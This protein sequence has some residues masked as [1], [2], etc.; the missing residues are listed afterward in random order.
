MA[1]RRLLH[2]RDEEVDLTLRIAH[3]G[4]AGVC[5][6]HDAVLAYVALVERQSADLALVQALHQL[7]AGQHVVRM[8]PAV[9]VLPAHLVFTVTEHL[10]QRAVDD[11]QASVRRRQVDTDR[12]VLEQGAE[13]QLAGAQSLFG[14][15]AVG[16]VTRHHH[17][18][19][20]RQAE[21]EVLHPQQ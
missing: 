21:H 17:Q 7:R 1:L 16:D 10:L 14:L 2:H 19:T 11:Q 12:G 20:A 5:P 9:E 8:G 18:I 4:D 3:D 6:N 13:A 15:L